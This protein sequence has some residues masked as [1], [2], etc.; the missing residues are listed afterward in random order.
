MLLLGPWGIESTFRCICF[1]YIMLS[2]I[3]HYPADC[4][5]DVFV[6]CIVILSLRQWKGCLLFS[7]LC[8]V[9]T[10]CSF[11]ALCVARVAFSSGLFRVAMWPMFF[12]GFTL[13]WP[14][15][16]T[17]VRA[18]GSSKAASLLFGMPRP[19]HATWIRLRDAR[20]LHRYSVQC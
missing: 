6:V 1:K 18:H 16:R 17:T 20:A 15:A 14:Q 5:C 2:I 12:S 9:G 10:A 11:T 4:F 7:W 13:A 8:V 3:S 19:A